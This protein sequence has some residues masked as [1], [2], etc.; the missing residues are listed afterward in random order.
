MKYDYVETLV[1]ITLYLCAALVIIYA[2]ITLYNRHS[3]YLM[4]QRSISFCHEIHDV[5]NV[6]LDE[7]IGL[8]NQKQ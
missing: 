1:L 8:Y 7:C 6:P 2:T 3:I 5:Y 4:E